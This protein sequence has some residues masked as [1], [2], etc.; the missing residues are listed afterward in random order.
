MSPTQQACGLRDYQ[1]LLIEQTIAQWIANK[2]RVKLQLATGAGKTVIFSAIARE[3]IGWGEPVLV[4][5][6]REELLLQAAEKLEIATGQQQQVGIIK[7]G[8]RASVNALIQVASVQTLARRQKLPPATLVIVDES[9]HSAA[10]SYVRLMEHYSDSYLLGCTATPARIDGQGFKYLYDELICGPS[11]SWLIEQGYLCRFKLFAARIAVK[12]AG[13]K[14]TGGDFNQRDLAEAVDTSLVMGD[15]IKTWQKYASGKK[16]VVFAVDVAHSKATATAYNDAGIPAEHLDGDTPVD[17]RR[18]ILERFR[19]GQ[20]LILTNCGIISEG[21]DVPS[22]QVIQCV[23]P[24]KSLILWLQMVGRCLRPAPGKEHAIII[25]HTQ[26]WIFHG[27]PDEE[28]EWSLEPVSLKSRTWSLQCPAC[29]HV[30]IPLPHERKRLLASCPNCTVMIQFE[31]SGEGSGFKATRIIAEDKH[32][33][34]EEV[35]L[36]PDPEMVAQLHR[37]N[38]IRLTHG[39]KPIWLYREFLAACPEVRL[40]E[41]RVCAKLLNYKPGWAWYRWLEIQQQRSK[42][43]A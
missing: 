13:V 23:R 14:T 6:H 41:L 16:T 26:N 10:A 8:Y 17:E 34:I 1:Q 28:R 29:Q 39:H 22:I 31:E 37:L 32:A 11:V 40:G 4:I 3:F 43:A 42:N 24:T 33:Q 7:A 15:L 25:D 9:H 38:E 21:F 36:A 19:V 27:L 2:R 30:F 5:A 18:D 35:G 20:T 12:T